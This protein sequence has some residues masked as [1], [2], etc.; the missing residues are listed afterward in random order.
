MTLLLLIL[1]MLFIKR[2]VESPSNV[3]N[4]QLT[5]NQLNINVLGT[6]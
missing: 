6:S 2:N 1:L 5:H 3:L 4:G